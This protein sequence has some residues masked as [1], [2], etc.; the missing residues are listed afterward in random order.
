MIVFDLACTAHGHVFEVWFGSSDDYESQRS[1]GLIA[2]PVCGATEVHKAAMAPNVAAKGNQRNL[3]APAVPAKGHA[4]LPMAG[5]EPGPAQIKAMMQALAKA[6]TEALKSSDYVGKGFADEARAIHLGESKQRAIHGE[7]TPDQAQALISEG[8]E[9]APL[10]F[11]VV[12]PE[13]LN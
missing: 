5:G 12:R 7:A 10:P 4:P 2:C 6:Q 11:P 9:V 3:P 8:I 13:S 1:R